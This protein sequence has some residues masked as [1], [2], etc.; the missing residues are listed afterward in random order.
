MEEQ[1]VLLQMSLP[2][3]PE[4]DSFGFQND[5]R[6]TPCRV[7]TRHL[8]LLE[9]SKTKLEMVLDKERKAPDAPYC[10]P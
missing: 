7:Y 1:I 10:F 6:L 3:A 4:R 8:D 2:F 9:K 5:Y